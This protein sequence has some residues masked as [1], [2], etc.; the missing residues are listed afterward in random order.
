GAAL[1]HVLGGVPE[2]VAVVGAG[3]RLLYANAEALRIWGFDD[4][5]HVPP[6]FQDFAPGFE[7]RDPEGV[8]VPVEG[9][10]ATRA[11]AGERLD[12][13]EFQLAR[14]DG[15]IRWVRC[16]GGAGGLG[17][18]QAGAW[19]SSRDVGREEAILR[20]LREERDLV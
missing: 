13:L 5:G 18:R 2:G 16:A 11:L 12:D 1:G 8:A 6:R 15:T 17:G 19:V 7:L 20:E 9:W 4:P 14:G 10:P 3:G